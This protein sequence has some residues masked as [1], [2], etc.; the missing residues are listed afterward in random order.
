[1]GFYSTLS[2]HHK[3][4]LLRALLVP[5]SDVFLP[6]TPP[7]L[8][9]A[10]FFAVVCGWLG[11]LTAALTLAYGV[12][13]GLSTA[14]PPIG[15]SAQWY[16]ALEVPFALYFSLELFFQVALLAYQRRCHRRGSAA[17]LFFRLL[18]RI[19]IAVVGW[20]E[21][22]P[23]LQ[24][25]YASRL[26]AL[27][28]LHLLPAL[29]ALD[30]LRLRPL[31]RLYFTSARDLAGLSCL[32]ILA[33]LLFALVGLQVWR[34]LTQGVCTYRDAGISNRTLESPWQL[35]PV[36][37]GLRSCPASQTCSLS[38]GDIC[39]PLLVPLASGP[40][41]VMQDCTS[42]NS[43]DFGFTNFDNVGAA[44]LVALVIPTLEGWASVM[45]NTWHVKGGSQQAIFL[46]FV[47]FIT[48]SGW[49]LIPLSMSILSLNLREVHNWEERHA[50]ELINE[51]HRVWVL[52]QDGQQGEGVGESSDPP[53]FPDGP[54]E[55]GQRRRLG[56]LV[57]IP[58]VMAALDAVQES[59]MPQRGTLGNVPGSSTAA[60]VRGEP[61]LSRTLWRLNRL[62]KSPVS[63][64]EARRQRSASAAAALAADSLQVPAAAPAGSQRLQRLRSF[65]RRSAV[66]EFGVSALLVGNVILFSSSYFGIS[67]REEAILQ[68]L[69]AVLVTLFAMEALVRGWAMGGARA[70]WS[71]P[72]RILEGVCTISGVI[73]VIIRGVGGPAVVSTSS[74]IVLLPTGYAINFFYS[75]RCLRLVLLPRVWPAYRNLLR[76]L[77]DA[78]PDIFGALLLLLLFILG[79]GLGSRQLFG[80]SYAPNATA[81][82]NFKTLQLSMLAIVQIAD[83]ENWDQLLKHHMLEVGPSSALFFMLAF[84]CGTVLSLNLL[85]SVFVEASMPAAQI[86]PAPPQKSDPQQP[87]SLLQQLFSGASCA[88]HAIPTPPDNFQAHV[89]LKIGPTGAATSVSLDLVDKLQRGGSG[90]PGGGGGGFQA[91]CD[92]LGLP[93]SPPQERAH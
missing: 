24:N 5:S 25:S 30:A 88:E 37:C 18:P 93:P 26:T 75:V 46:F 4:R 69:D 9:S 45:Y 81:F 60:I 42:Y 76:R 7:L 92:F 86:A 1:M 77:Y 43:P 89:S 61:L 87:T 63:R 48:I 36:P 22:S 12:L 59:P 29:G 10:H 33:A 8:K 17:L 13:L 50:Q 40:A 21:V 39:Q 35:A 79:F 11:A 73:Q 6:S 44:G 68:A 19:A 23:S 14:D 78:F 85:T 67:A 65:A 62:F 90:S 64:V 32:Y 80:K 34:G 55:L 91:S 53:I 20:L 70:F 54:G 28:L 72:E 84:F 3:E 57:C 16:Q 71:N 58:T 56:S 52:A 47:V 51:A 31:F 83:N 38:E 2:Q 82:P 74:G 66:W 41:V 49:L 27:R 15:S